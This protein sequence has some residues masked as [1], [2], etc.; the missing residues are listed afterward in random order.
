MSIE[1]LREVLAYYRRQTKAN[2]YGEAIGNA[3]QE[4]LAAIKKAARAFHEDMDPR[5]LH[6]APESLH[7][8]MDLMTDIAEEEP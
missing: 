4:E 3:A 5:A 1:N 8:A 6:R 2:S 7:E